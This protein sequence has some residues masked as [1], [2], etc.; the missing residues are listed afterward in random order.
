MNRFL[1]ALDAM[2]VSSKSIRYLTE[3]LNAAGLFEFVLFHALP[4]ASPNLLT[5]E[6]VRRI[7]G[8]HKLKPHLS[9]YFWKNEDEQQMART[10]E[11]ARQ[12]LVEAGFPSSSVSTYFDVQSVEVSQL[13]IQA[14]RKLRCSTI[15]LGRR[16]LS[17]MKELLLGST[18]VSVT[19]LGRDFTVWVVDA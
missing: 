14:A 16:R 12:M 18:S 2:Q 1:I 10:F 15:V 11:T 19:R 9:G 17:R 4:T 7:E 6:E 8:L 3:V 5:H 13:I